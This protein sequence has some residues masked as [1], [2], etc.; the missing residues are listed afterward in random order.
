VSFFASSGFLS[1]SAYLVCVSA[2]NGSGFNG[3]GGAQPCSYSTSAEPFAQE[4]GGTSV[5]TP[6]MA[7]VMALINEKTGAAQGSPNAG[8]YALA[9][10]QTYSSCSAESV[11]AGG[12]CYFNDIDQGTI[13]M[14]CDYDAYVTTPSP[15]CTIS[16]SG[17]YVGI[18]TDPVSGAA[19]FNATTGYDLATGLG[20]LNVANVVNAWTA[21]TPGSATPTVTVTPSPS[22]INSNNTLSVTV[23][24]AGGSGAPKDGNGNTIVPTGSVTLTASGSTYTATGTLAAS[25]SYAFTIP[26]NSLPGTAGGQSDTLTAR[27]AGDVNYAAK[28]GTGTVTVTT[29]TTSLLTPTITPS[30]TSQSVNSE[31]SFTEKVTVSGSGIIPT[32]TVTL[33]SG[34]FNSG[35]Q[36]LVNGVYTFTVGSANT[37][38]PL[39][40]GTDTM[41]ISY[42]GDSNY[43]PGTPATATVTITESTFTLTPGA[44][45]SSSV[46]PGQSA[47][48]VVT[49]APTAN[50]TGTVSLACAFTS[51][52]TESYSDDAPTCSGSNSGQINLATCGSSCTVTFTIGTTASFTV[53]QN[54]RP[55]L[56][57]SGNR[58]W[59]GAGSGTVLALL[60]FFGI[61]ARRRSWRSMLSILVAMAVIGT[62]ASCGGGGNSGGGGGGGYTD[63]GTAAGTYTFT[64]TAT[65]NPTVTPTVTKTFTVTVN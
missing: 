46:T 57:G 35:P 47:T 36:A 15:N 16:H 18:L 58:E 50:Y 11:T 65:G 25:G 29:S 56:P 41:T 19:G 27:Y 43:S 62:L 2:A 59:L 40:A 63:P 64:L 37:Q 12:S 38:S 60:V 3:Y 32:G 10:K 22:S 53:A 30:P 13:A 23:T 5:A 26:A 39:A 55:N 21:V 52:P 9:S 61:P 51:G 54:R 20:S 7:G 4:V 17:D 42:S 45:S 6:A 48:V 24:I 34:S 33:T 49:A 31:G 44:P 28:T 8:L 1:S 14:P